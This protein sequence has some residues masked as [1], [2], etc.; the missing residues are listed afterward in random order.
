MNFSRR[1]FVAGIFAF[2]AALT[3]NFPALAQTAGKDYTV[4]PSIQPTEEPGR[5]EVLEF[6][7][8]G[9]G[10]CNSFYP[11]LSAWIGKLPA[12][13]VV[14][15]V[16]VGFNGYFQ[17]LAPIYYVLEALGEVDRLDK[18]VFKSIHTDGMRLVDAK[19]RAQWASK[20]GLD[21]RKFEE[22]YN[23]FS[24]SSKVRRAN[25]M[26]QAYQVQG[27]PALAIEG[28]YMISGKEPAEALA[29]ADKLIAKARSEKAGKK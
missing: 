10:H 22:L 29:I 14:R 9:C 26:M 7:S 3:V 25:Q 19:E 2:G 24:V 20:N 1:D 6:F 8:Y 18:V 23:S 12:D 27:V 11:N 28:K 4:L 16:P 15:K 17:V 21:A 13:V 5:I